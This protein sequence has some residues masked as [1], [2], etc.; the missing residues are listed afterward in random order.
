MNGGS[1]TTLQEDLFASM[2]SLTFIH[3][4]GH[5]QLT[6]FPSFQGLVNLKSLSLAVFFQ[7]QTLSSFVFTPRLERLDLFAMLSLSTLPDLAPLSHLIHLAI[8]GGGQMCCNGFLGSPCDLS[9]PLCLRAKC[10]NHS[11]DSHAS[12]RTLQRFQQ[13]ADSVC[14]V[15]PSHPAPSRKPNI[16]N[17]VANRQCPPNDSGSVGICVSLHMT[18]VSCQY[19]DTF[20]S[21]RKK[22]IERGEG[23]PCNPLEESWLGCHA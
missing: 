8:L 18:V 20:I 17:N 9:H 12:N 13:F 22:Q 14:V 23:V 11:S 15:D 5:G 1:L 16:C 7:V 21:A 4:A 2:A 3:F 6:T 19:S 10:L